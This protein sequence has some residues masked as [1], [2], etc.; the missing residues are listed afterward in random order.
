MKQLVAILFQNVPSGVGSHRKDL[1]LDAKDLREVMSR[2]ASWAISRGFGSPSDLD[3][4]EAKGCI[5]GAD[6]SEVSPRAM[7]RGRSQIGT[8]GSGNHFVEIGY[9]D[10]IYDEPTA[11]VLGLEKDSVTV[12]IH[13]G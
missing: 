13:T 12:I 11:R 7:E 6:P 10:E 1:R 2:G 4:I 3:S 8:L 5:G 9:V